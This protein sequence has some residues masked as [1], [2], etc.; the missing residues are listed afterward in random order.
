MLHLLVLTVANKIHENRHSKEYYHKGRKKFEKMKKVEKIG[1]ER[2]SV[3]K[4]YLGDYPREF[5][6]ND[7]LV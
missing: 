4:F 1:H 6:T 3:P 5:G 7:R 2:F